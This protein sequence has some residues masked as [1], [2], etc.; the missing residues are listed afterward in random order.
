MKNLTYPIIF[1][2]LIVVTIAG[3]GCKEDWL[4]PAPE[5]TLIQSDSTF[6][7]AANAEKFVNACY[8]WTTEWGQHVF[9]WVGVSSITS[10]D[11]DKGSDPGDLGADKDQMDALSYT[12]TSLSPAEVWEANYTGIGRCNQAIDKVTN[13]FKGVIDQAL[14]DRLV[15]EAK[16]LRAYYYFNLVR[17]FGAV[18]KFDRVYTSDETALIYEDYTRVPVE[19][20]YALIEA[21][22]TDAVAKLPLK[23]AY[24]AKDLGRATKGSA[25]G[26]L[27]KVYMYQKKWNESLAAANDVINSGEYSLEPDY[28]LIWRQ[29][30]EHGAESLFEVEGQNGGEGWGIGGY[31]VCQGARGGVSGGFGGWG[32]NTPTVDLENAYES[33][34]V[35]KDATIYRAGQTLWDG[36]QVDAGVAN[37]RYNYKAY[38]SQTQEIN[39]SDWWSGKNIRVLRYAEI[40]LI[41]AEAANELGNSGEAVAALNLVRNRAGLADTNASSQDDLRDAIWRER[42]V[43]L[44]MEHD[45]FFDLVRQGRAGQVLRAHGKDFVDGKHE[46]FPI[47]QRQIDLSGGVLKQNPGY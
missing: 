16:F 6:T 21:D 5:N 29:S 8:A 45:R 24:E 33:G 23:S 7:D 44:A 46:L 15:G 47:P 43:E 34:D 39:Y 17:I 28:A 42:R 31:F 3:A 18:P 13:D 35:R 38:A 30:T 40:L 10:D 20:I 32:F 12:P 4:S 37:P 26:L 1:L 9:S 25:Q 19:E 11:A 14:A 22:L 41:K 36:A 27:A 2:A